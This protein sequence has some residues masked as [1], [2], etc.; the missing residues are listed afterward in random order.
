MLIP[1]HWVVVLLSF[2][3]SAELC[4]TVYVEWWVN[5]EAVTILILHKTIIATVREFL[6][7]LKGILTDAFSDITATLTRLKTL[8]DENGKM[9]AVSSGK[10][11]KGLVFHRVDECKH[12]GVLKMH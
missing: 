12:I 7:P 6:R 4:G 5:F 3:G 10:L 2:I 1:C 11:L 8:L 9:K